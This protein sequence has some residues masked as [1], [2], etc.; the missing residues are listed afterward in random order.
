[1]TTRQQRARQAQFGEDHRRVGGGRRIEPH[2][3]GEQR[4]REGEEEQED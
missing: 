3:P 1:M 4:Q 2:A